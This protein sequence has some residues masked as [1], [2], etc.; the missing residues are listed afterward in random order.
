MIVIASSAKI[1]DIDNSGTVAFTFDNIEVCKPRIGWFVNYVT[2]SDSTDNLW[3]EILDDKAYAVSDGSYFPTLQTGAVA[4]I[5]STR[6]GSQ[7]I[8]GG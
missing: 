8:K 5:V 6:D 2:T 1:L 3:N 4:W 7:W